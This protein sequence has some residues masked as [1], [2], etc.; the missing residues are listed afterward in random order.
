MILGEGQSYVRGALI[1]V[2][3]VFT[4]AAG[5]PTDP[6]VVRF[7]WKS[8]AGAVTTYV[9]PTD[10]ALVKDSVGNYHVDIDTTSAEGRY[11]YRFESTGTGQ[12]ADEGN[13]TVVHSQ[14]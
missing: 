14:F 9:Y 10:G 3:G 2:A 5:S 1:R 6:T 13:F 4:N 12:A 11:Y 7:K 8:P